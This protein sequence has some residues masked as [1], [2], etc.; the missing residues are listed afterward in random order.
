M[1]YREVLTIEEVKNTFQ[2]NKKFLIRYRYK[3]RLVKSLEDRLF[4]L[5]KQMEQLNSPVITDM[6]GGGVPTTLN[7]RYERKEELNERINHVLV[8]ARKIRHEITDVFDQL[9][10]AKQSRVLELYFIDDLSLESIAEQTNYSLR[11]INR[12]YSDGVNACKPPMTQE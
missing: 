12:L 7:D 3:M 1:L 2:Q 10:N 8:E 4:E 6:P 11:Q 9:E 5:D